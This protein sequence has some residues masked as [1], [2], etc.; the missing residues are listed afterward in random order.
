M[1]VLAIGCH[2]DDIEI[3]GCGTLAKCVDRGDHVVVCHVANGNMVEL[4]ICNNDGMAS[5]AISALNV[6]GFNTGA[7]NSV[8]IPV[9]GVDATAAARELIAQGKMAGTIRQDSDG[10]AE[11][12]EK[13][14]RNHLDGKDVT[15]GMDKF[16]VDGKVRKIRIPY[17]VYTGENT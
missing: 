13:A 5:G 9:F 7:E 14:V 12:I 3:S 2:P 6:A 11:A 16:N 10:M 8:S 1:N 4:I 15:E 17:S